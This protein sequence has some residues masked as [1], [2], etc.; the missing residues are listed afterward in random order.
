MD[1][2]P[3]AAADSSPA[4]TSRLES[5]FERLPTGVA[6]VDQHGRF[7]YVNPVLKRILGHNRLDLADQNLA[8]L[9]HPADAAAIRRALQFV[10]RDG[11]ARQLE[12]RVVG[13]DG[14]TRWCLIDFATVPGE[15]GKPARVVATFHEITQRKEADER[16]RASAERYRLLVDRANDIIFNIDLRGRFTFVNPTA[17]RLMKYPEDQLIGTHFR[18]LIRPDYRDEAERFYTEQV[19]RRLPSTY[20]EFPVV[21]RDHRELWLGQYVQLIIDGARI[22]SVQAVARDIT[23]R[24]RAEKALRTSEERLR[25]VVSSAPVIL[26]ASD[27]DGKFT[28][29]EGQGLIG[30]GLTPKELVGQSVRARFQDPQ[31]DEYLRRAIAGD[32]F[33]VELAMGGRTFDARCS[34]MRDGQARVTGVIGVAVD[35]TEHRVLQDRLH[36]AD[37][38]EA[39]GQLAGG[40]AH[41]F[42]NQ[43]TAILGYAEMLSESLDAKDD[44]RTDLQEIT[45]AGRRAAAVT[46]QLL[47]F[48]R[49]QPLRPRVIDLN[50]VIGNIEQLLRR[51]VRDDVSFETRLE[52]T[53][54]PVRAD[55]T[56]IEHVI[57]NLVLNAR[58]A[59]P[60][61]GRLTL[62]TATVDLDADEVR[63]QEPM[64]P[65]RYTVIEVS[66]TGRGMDE[67]T[68]AHLFEPFF[69]TK[70]TGKG[71]G[72]GLASV[73]GIVKQSG[74]YIW[75]TS[76]VGRG[77]TFRIYLPTVAGPVELA[78][79]PSMAGDPVGG[80]ETIL[81]VEDNATVR[82]LACDILASHGYEVLSAENPRDALEVSDR[83]PG[84]I[85]LLFTDV[86]M[87]GMSGGELAEKFAE[88]RPGMGVVF[89]TGYA[90][91]ETFRRHQIDQVHLL[92]KPF[93]PNRLL[94]KVREALDAAVGPKPRARRHR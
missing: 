3:K 93:V 18:D 32:A 25:A 34:P 63:H 64:R 86:V 6:L 1:P 43:L 76:A 33:Q 61:G 87:P 55:P 4:G 42:N 26:W 74:G 53:L 68:R 85:D 30:L 69:T 36:E 39:I 66:D 57:M 11:H 12:I 50:T 67:E 7:I 29:C 70:G 40:V 31:V 9:T 90:K 94:R 58:D 83:H 37:K 60:T 5:V 15:G 80:A 52:K 82:A 16:L 56:Q 44:R 23:E 65:G 54:E 49:K 28:L 51:S 47:A 71:T 91:D 48:G 62:T 13:A 8:G 92:E 38:M 20:F 75:V 27:L 89:T 21:T 41:D 81:V 78:D 19:D 10:D 79:T 73:Y 46:E 22:V 2:E 88:L 45:R 77:T 24:K 84:E 35:I 59:M 17:S 72:L 14:R